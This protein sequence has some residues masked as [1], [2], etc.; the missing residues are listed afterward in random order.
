MTIK[1]IAALAGVSISTVSKIVNNK[2]QNIAA[3]TR[4]KVLKIVKEYNYT[5]YG[6]VKNLSTAKTFILGVVLSNMPRTNSML[7]GIAEAAAEH[8]YSI[9]LFDSQNR[10]DFELKH[11]NAL[12]QKRV[13]GV[14]WEPVNAESHQLEHYL[15]DQNIPFIHIMEKDNPRSF[16]INYEE[17]GYL[18]TQ[19][20]IDYKHAKIACLIKPDSQRSMMVLEGFRK[21]LFD[22]HI[23][24]HNSM[25]ISIRNP[26]YL[27]ELLGHKFS[28]VVSS[29]FSSSLALYED[30]DRL[31]Y[32]IPS[33]L[34]VVSL[35]DE[36][37][38]AISYPHISSISI[39]YKEFGYHIGKAM[40]RKCE[41]I[42]VTEETFSFS[43]DYTLDTE[44][45]LY[46]PFFLRSKKI[47]VVGS[48]NTDLTFNVDSLPQ[49]GKATRIL[50]STFSLGGKG[51]NQAVGAAKLDREVSLIGE[52]GNDIDSNLIFDQLEKEHVITQGIQR[53]PNFPT[54][55]AYIYIEESGESAI[56]V[57]AGAN[58]NL[59]PECIRQRQHLFK[60]SGCCLIS[61]ELTN[62][63]TLEAAKTARQ[64]GAKTFL[65]P[66]VIKSMPG[67]LCSYIDYFIPNRYEASLLSP[68]EYGTVEDQAEYFF[69][70]GIPNVIITLGSRGCYLKTNDTAR[71]FPAADFTPIDTTGGADAF[72]SCLASCLTDGYSL[73]KSIRIANYAAGFCV[74]RQGVVPAL[75]DRTTLES[76][77]KRIEP[78]LLLHV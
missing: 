56:S 26:D 69:S 55:K 33:D 50:N 3:E 74:A 39:P 15:T 19:R 41:K 59:T 29:H 70:Q 40:I 30:I 7:S 6:M 17:M 24:Y 58:S 44:D 13:D 78:E 38:E 64:Y 1:E 73:E 54:G 37:R 34:S 10:P 36:V 71:Y 49:T 72:I 51:A 68:P 21:C 11:I 65:K 27:T 32:S 18:L 57:L 52:I 43:G 77:I 31:H 60:N 53:N 63:T 20:L 28:G 23:P 8:N 42:P 66:T 4:N 25:E 45:S 22:N 16:K 67:D 14:I 61:T 9:L 75:V 62:E 12:S 76:H 48:I 5:P 46:V 47:V 35:K 2:D